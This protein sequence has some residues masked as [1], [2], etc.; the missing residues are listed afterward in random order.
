M[1]RVTLTE[2]Q[3]TLNLWLGSRGTASGR[4]RHPQP[5]E[6]ARPRLGGAGSHVPPPNKPAV[7]IEPIT[8]ADERLARDL[9]GSDVSHAHH[10]EMRGGVVEKLQAECVSHDRALNTGFAID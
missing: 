2:R 5:V 8:A 9:F 6:P 1:G 7:I 3:E 4:G 10:T